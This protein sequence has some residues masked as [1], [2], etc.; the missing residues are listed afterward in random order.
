LPPVFGQQA[1]DFARR[2]MTFDGVTFNHRGVA[3]AEFFG[4]AQAFAHY[5]SVF[6]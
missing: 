2:H 4:N 5:C 3:A 1:F 6:D